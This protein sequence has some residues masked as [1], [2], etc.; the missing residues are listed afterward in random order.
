MEIQT[1][2]EPKPRLL[3]HACCG[4]CNSYV[5]ELLLPNFDV[6]VYYENSNIYPSEEF[7]RRLEAAKTMAESFGIPFIQ[8]PYKPEE[9][10]A[11][12]KGLENAPEKGARCSYCVAFRLAKTLDFAKQMDFEWV[13]TTLSVSRRKNAQMINDIGERL[14]VNYGINFLGRDWKKN[15]G[16]NISQ[17]RAK[18]AGI[19]R[20]NYCGCIFSYKARQKE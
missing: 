20:Q 6:T 3:L 7:D 10:L 2:T 18:K 13:A 8:A 12:T 14:S 11:G 17:E 9:W 16:E 1:N 19:Y 5:P 4:V 15:G